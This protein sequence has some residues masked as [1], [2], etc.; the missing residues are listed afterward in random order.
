MLSSDLENLVKVI[1]EKKNN[2]L[3]CVYDTTKKTNKIRFNLLPCS[4]IC[5]IVKN[6]V[7]DDIVHSYIAKMERFSNFLCPTK[8]LA[9]H[10]L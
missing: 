2:V 9:S 1:E 10:W 5:Y 3:T 8:F 6:K 4:Q 7:T